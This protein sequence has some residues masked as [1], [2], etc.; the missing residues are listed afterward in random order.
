MELPP[1][2]LLA[3]DDI[4]EL[5]QTQIAF[6]VPKTPTASSEQGLCSSGEY[7]VFLG[8]LFTCWGYLTAHASAFLSHGIQNPTPEMWPQLT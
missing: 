5:P 2:L 1:A 8:L 6:P 4:A 7:E 3:G